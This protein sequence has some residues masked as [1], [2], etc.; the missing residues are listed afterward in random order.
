M[1]STN[2]TPTIGTHNG[3]FHCDDALACYM[4]TRLPQYKHANI[5][6]TRDQAVLD[7][8]DV[9]VDV[10]SV[11]DHNTKRYDHHQKQFDHCLHSLEP[12][13]DFH[14][15][16]SSA[17]LVYHHY[18]RQII[19]NILDLKDNDNEQIE[20]VFDKV[21]ENFLQEIDGIDNGI[22]MF[23]GPPKYRINTNL[24]TRVS[25]LTPVWNEKT[26]EEILYQRYISIAFYVCD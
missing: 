3:V 12:E 17:G 8:C 19:Q 23:D 2:K 14:I 1:G 16:L 15:K 25:F 9:V 20:S 4:L 5:V 22:E 10:G 11:Y 6:R 7:N 26:S 18:G 21:Y 13:K 24:S